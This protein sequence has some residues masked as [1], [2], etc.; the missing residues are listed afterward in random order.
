M[1]SRLSRYA[2][3][4]GE[5]QARNPLE[6]FCTE[7]LAF[8][9]IHSPVF[10]QKF[11][12]VIPGFEKPQDAIIHIHTQDTLEENDKIVGYVDLVIEAASNKFFNIEI[13]IGA[14]LRASQEKYADVVLA[15]RAYFSRYNIPNHIHQLTWQ[16]V[17]ELLLSTLSDPSTENVADTHFV[18]R[19]F[20][21]FLEE[22]KLRHI[23]M[24][25]NIQDINDMPKVASLL[26]EWTDLLI[27]LR[28]IL[29]MS[30]KGNPPPVWDT[31]SLKSDSTF[32]GIYDAKYRYAGF[33]ILPEGKVSCYYQ[34]PLAGKKPIQG[35]GY[36]VDLG[37]PGIVWV[38]KT[39]DYPAGSHDKGDEIQKL[40]SDLQ[41]DLWKFAEKNNL[42]R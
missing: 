38:T 26:N 24:K 12:A 33:E 11:I 4:E 17:H 15:P 25:T 28:E 18:L 22:K 1:F 6:D 32:Y 14:P 20:A 10:Q 42:V 29:Q 5:K 37:E 7:A 23:P 40:F 19:Q 2:P 31:P 9:L 3:R 35:E 27:S 8:C 13:K 30:Q 36:Q 16:K 34:E 39:A 21:D 41:T